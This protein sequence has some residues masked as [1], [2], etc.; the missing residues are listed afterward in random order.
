MSNIL[1]NCR[2]LLKKTVENFEN[3]KFFKNIQEK[4]KIR[5]ND[6]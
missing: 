2:K 1:K 6:I 3:I 5:K 4:Q